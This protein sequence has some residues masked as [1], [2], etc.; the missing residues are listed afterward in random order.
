MHAHTHTHTQSKGHTE[1]NYSKYRLLLV[2]QVK[3]ASFR[4]WRFLQ[5]INMT[6]F[7]DSFC[8]FFSPYLH[9]TDK[10]RSSCQIWFTESPYNRGSF[11]LV[12][13]Q[14]SI[15]VDRSLY[16]LI[17]GAKKL[18]HKSYHSH[19]KARI[20]LS[21]EHPNAIKVWNNQYQGKQHF[22]DT[23]LPIKRLQLDWNL[24]QSFSIHFQSHR[25]SV[26]WAKH[27]TE[28]L[29]TV[30]IFW[31]GGGVRETSSNNPSPLSK[32]ELHTYTLEQY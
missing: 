28:A 32:T 23:L 29:N 11:D 31:G 15:T 16:L 30:I 2:L 18:S 6:S 13:L 21:I 14:S 24:I 26:N 27:C 5:T 25:P 1:F 9:K 10:I 8:P 19:E 7:I 17:Y 22:G 4:C 3:S 20:V 12:F